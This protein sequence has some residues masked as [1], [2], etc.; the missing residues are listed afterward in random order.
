[1]APPFTQFDAADGNTVTANASATQRH[2]AVALGVFKAERAQ[3]LAEQN[4]ST[5]KP[6]GDGD[7]LSA[8]D[9]ATNEVAALSDKAGVIDTEPLSGADCQVVDSGKGLSSPDLISQSL[10][11]E[12]PQKD[13]PKLSPKRLFKGLFNRQ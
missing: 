13:S 5:Y 4:A 2:V 3:A 12:S 9:A 6:Q 1:M 7:S 8:F 10:K 11:A